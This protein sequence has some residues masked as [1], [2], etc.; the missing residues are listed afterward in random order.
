MA[1]R[2]DDRQVLDYIGSLYEGDFEDIYNT[3]PEELQQI[4]LS[5]AEAM[6]VAQIFKM[7]GCKNILELGVLVGH[8]TA[9]L[10]TK[11][12]SVQV[13]AIENNREHYLK[14]QY[15]LQN[16]GILNVNLI[17]IDAADFGM[18]YSGAQFD[19]IFIDANKAGYPKY[20]EMFF[21]YLKKGGVIVA[22]NTLFRGEVASADPSP[23]NKNIV[24]ALKEYNK[25]AFDS[26]R[27]ESIIIPTTEGLTVS[28]KK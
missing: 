5:Y 28:V 12:P 19:G 20:L 13:T 17:N 23:K 15:N 22:D 18:S 25:L 26:E 27:F 16:H 11:I 21:P 3:A 1:R 6:V 8:S 24:N 2:D 4:Q 10:A 9:V 14:A 7:R